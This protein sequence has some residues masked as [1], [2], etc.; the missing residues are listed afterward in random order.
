MINNILF[1]S[2]PE[3]QCGVHEFGKNVAE[4]IKSSSKYNFIYAECGSMDDLRKAIDQHQPA[5]IIYNY[6][7]STLPWLREKIIHKTF[8]SLNKDIAVPQIGIMHEVTQ[9]K[10]NLADT[11]LFDYHI[12]P[13]PTLLLK[14]PIVYKTGRL[15]PRYDNRFTLPEIP[16]IGSFGFAT[17]N[18]GFEDVV[19]AVDKEFDSAVIRFNIPSADFGD[20]DGSNAK[21]IVE[22][23]RQ[24]ITK[25]G[26]KLD[27]SHDFLS[28][29]QVLAFLAQN[30]LNVFLYQ[31]KRGRGISSTTDYAL[32]VD[33]PVAVSDSIMFRHLHHV[34]PSVVYGRA[35]LKDIIN[36][37]TSPLKILIR[38]WD[39][40]N[41]T[42]EYER[43][44]NSVLKREIEKKTNQS[45]TAWKQLKTS[46][47]TMLGLQQKSFTWLRNTV[48]AA[49]DSM[50]VVK[51]RAYTPV[52]LQAGASLNRILDNSARVQYEPAIK[53]LN[54]LVP[55]TMAKK[56]A[57]ANVQQAFVFDTVHRFMKN[58][59]SPKIL[60]VGS[61][62]DTAAMSLKKMGYTI[63][64]IDPVSN[65][66][67]QE[68]FSKPTTTKNS[69]D[70]IFSTSVIEHD[71]DDES[72]V[73]CIND[74]LAPGGVAIITCDYNDQWKPGDPK[75]EVD[76]RLYTQNDLRNRLLPLMKSCELVDDPQWNC[77]SPDFNY[78]GKYQYTF[79]TLVVKKIKY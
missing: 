50:T 45:P 54:E 57:E 53:T 79:A 75:P 1:I 30:T 62:E 47:R 37:G 72:F 35:S 55:L 34:E 26:I 40:S 21:R 20:K 60:C 15:I 27:V 73:Q 69:Y 6:Y 11:V 51:G 14:N 36:H 65:Y 38:D 19:R 16:V 63:E 74:L 76:A 8:R 59:S 18:K 49:E 24:L 44:V 64:D 78:L 46:V 56:I 9:E 28:K 68:Y 43:I 5:A 42:W 33:R 52:Q 41:L 67:L 58:Y 70:I 31:D 7:A 32:A 29:N 13:D 3:K 2:H 4:T 61:Y 39:E 12:A 10:A 22:A 17:P 23:C 25:P 77:P 48:A 71:P 66:Y